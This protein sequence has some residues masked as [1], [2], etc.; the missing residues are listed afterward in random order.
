MTAPRHI[1]TFGLKLAGLGLRYRVQRFSF[2]FP[3]GRLLRMQPLIL[4]LP[5]RRAALPIY[6]I[7]PSTLGVGDSRT[8]DLLT[9]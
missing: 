1:R 3:L 2:F 5:T 8:L 6:S 7:G 9:P 4:R